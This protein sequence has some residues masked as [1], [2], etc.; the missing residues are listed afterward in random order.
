MFVIGGM[1]GVEGIKAHRNLTGFLFCIF[2]FFFNRNLSEEIILH[3]F[4]VFH[5]KLGN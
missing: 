4:L 3:S 5:G 2:A 1:M